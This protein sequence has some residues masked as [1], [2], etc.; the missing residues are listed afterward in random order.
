MKIDRERVSRVFNDYVAQYDLREEKIR[1]KA[2]HTLR[3]ASLCEQIAASQGLGE[4]DRDLAWLVGMLH[5]VGRF[6]QLRLFSTFND[7]QSL[8]HARFGAQ[9][10]FDEGKIRDY[11]R[12]TQEDELLETAISLHSAYR[13]PEKLEERTRLFCCLIRDADKIDILKVNVDFSMEEIYNVTA[14]QLR[15]SLIS[16]AVLQAFYEEHAVLRSLKQTPLDNLIGHI[17]LVYELEFPYSL[18]IVR[19]QGY[20]ERLM[21][22]SSDNPETRRQLIKVRAHME[23]YLMRKS[24]GR[25]QK[26]VN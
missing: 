19:E 6:E 14:R 1:L 7:A 21:A 11:V 26:N 23:E 12:E 10:L 16:E 17:S 9:L 15:E 8:D 13:L 24:E 3:V 22:F 4:E 5:D 20:L 18:R 2:E 25:E